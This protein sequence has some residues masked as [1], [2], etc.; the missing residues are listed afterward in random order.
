MLISVCVCVWKEYLLRQRH[1]SYCPATFTLLHKNTFILL[2]K[3][4]AS[5]L[6]HVSGTDI[7][8]LHTN[9]LIKQ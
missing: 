1:M 5:F 8:K 4:H 7:L 3:N 6:N 2:K 9:Y